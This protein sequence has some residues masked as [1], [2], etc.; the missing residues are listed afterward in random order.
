MD[1]KL[2]SNSDVA[3]EAFKQ[4]GLALQFASESLRNSVLTAR[5][6]IVNNPKAIEFATEKVKK[7]PEI[8][9]ILTKLGTHQ[10]N[11]PDKILEECEV[12]SSS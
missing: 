2:K 10:K 11:D 1:D 5:Y 9:C 7:D 6:A 4:N 12:A 8:M 3:I